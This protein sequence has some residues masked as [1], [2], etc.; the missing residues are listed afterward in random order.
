MADK[1][2]DMTE[3]EVKA[4]RGCLNALKN[5]LN[6]ENWSVDVVT[7]WVDEERCT[8]KPYPKR[9]KATI[10]LCALWLTESPAE[11]LGTLVHELLHAHF[12]PFR[13]VFHAD[14]WENRVVSRGVYDILFD[15]LDRCEEYM[16]DDLSYVLADHAAGHCEID[17][18][19]ILDILK[20]LNED[21]NAKLPVSC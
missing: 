11:Q 12:A 5:I 19:P 18:K 7:T 6:L 1:A 3:G 13:E 17:G 15:A 4:I 21:H 10:K 20:S 9:H 8:F 14:L 2:R 16:V